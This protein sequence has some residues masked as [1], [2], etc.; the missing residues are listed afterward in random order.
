VTENEENASY[1]K[2]LGHPTRLMIAQELLRGPKNV[3]EVERSLN[4]GQA[5]T[6]QHLYILRIN[7]IVDSRRKGNIKVYSLKEPKKIRRI[8]D[9]LE[10]CNQ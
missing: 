8:I 1:L 6:S 5:N 2:A 10:T 4:I 9:A 7:G 3:G